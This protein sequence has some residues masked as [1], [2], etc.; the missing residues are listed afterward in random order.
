MKAAKKFSEEEAKKIFTQILDTLVYI[1]SQG[2]AHSDLKL[3]NILYDEIASK[4]TVIDFGGSMFVNELEDQTTHK[5]FCTPAYSSPEQLQNEQGV[6]LQKA[7]VWAL[8]VLL[9][10]L[11]TGLFPFRAK[12]ETDLRKKILKG[13]ISIPST[14]VLSSELKQLL[15]S[16]LVPASQRP[17]CLQIKSDPW[18]LHN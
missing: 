4:V 11:T 17:S 9:F 10:K 2:V 12:T 1:H 6:N 18:L 5:V 8:G 13:E 3:E 15:Q 14:I 16:M 7:D